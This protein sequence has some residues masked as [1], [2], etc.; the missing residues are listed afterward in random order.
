MSAT[1]AAPPP[2]LTENKRQHS[3]ITNLERAGAWVVKIHQTGRGRRGLP[4]IVACYRGV[5]LAIEV[6]QPGASTNQ[7]RR[8][9]QLTELHAVRAAGGIS[10]IATSYDDVQPILNDIDIH[11]QHHTMSFAQRPLPERKVIQL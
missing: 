11:L 5:F 9:H 3:I 10:V 7:A 8:Q 1:V 4:D 2:K 6:K